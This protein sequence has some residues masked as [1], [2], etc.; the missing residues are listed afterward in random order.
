MRPAEQ[1]H[2]PLAEQERR[3]NNRAAVWALLQDG[4]WHSGA[5]LVG[6]GG[7]RF[8]ARIH[9]LRHDQG[10]RIVSRVEGGFSSYRLIHAEEHH[11]A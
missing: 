6:V 4:A 1:L 10:A 9:E 3:R 11:D 8:G 5:E 7:L 2:L